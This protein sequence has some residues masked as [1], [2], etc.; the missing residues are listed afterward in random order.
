MS[1]RRP[2]RTRG[3]AKLRKLWEEVSAEN[4]ELM[5]YSW[6]SLLGTDISERKYLT[7]WALGCFSAHDGVPAGF[8]AAV[9]AQA[10]YEKEAERNRRIAWALEWGDVLEVETVEE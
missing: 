9:E 2:P 8:L 4:P 1:A 3:R 5:G 6:W 10:A 7:H